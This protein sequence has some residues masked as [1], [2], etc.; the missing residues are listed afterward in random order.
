MKFN[1]TEKVGYWIDAAIEEHGQGENI[2]WEAIVMSGPQQEPLFTVFLW[3]PGAL[4]GTTLNASFQLTDPL[5]IEKKDISE[6]MA[7]FL[8]HL[9]EARSQILAQQNAAAQQQPPA[10]PGAPQTPSGLLIP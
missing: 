2:L 7:E 6:M 10:P 1:I 9:R 5:H 3:F 8:R 4:M